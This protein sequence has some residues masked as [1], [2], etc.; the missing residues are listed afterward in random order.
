MF[1]LPSQSNISEVVI[2]KDVVDGKIKP[3][4][5]YSKKNNQATTSSIPN[6]KESKIG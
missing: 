5:T 6:N 4:L 1:E 3:L 2:N